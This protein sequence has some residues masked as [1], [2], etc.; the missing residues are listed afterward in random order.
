MP[1]AA[2]GR[3]DAELPW[4]EEE[5]I[6]DT[7]DEDDP[8]VLPLDYIKSTNISGRIR[9]LHYATTRSVKIIR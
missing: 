6:E 3:L 8:T 4:L 9:C 5:E 7:D 2:A 1:D